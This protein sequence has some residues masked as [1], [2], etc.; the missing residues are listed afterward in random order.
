[1]CVLRQLLDFGE[2]EL[3]VWQHVVDTL[4]IIGA[5]VVDLC[6]VLLL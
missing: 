4:R 1:M 2:L 6:Q 3:G 5:D